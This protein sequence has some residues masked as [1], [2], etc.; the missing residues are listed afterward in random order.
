[1]S[2]QEGICTLTAGARV[3]DSPERRRPTTDETAGRLLVWVGGVALGGT[4]E[5]GRRARRPTGERLVDHRVGQSPS[6]QLLAQG[7]LAA[8]MR[9]IAGLDPG[10]GKRGVIQQP[11]ADQAVEGGLDELRPVAGVAE[12]ASRLVD[13]ARSRL[14]I[15]EPGSE[16]AIRIVDRRPVGAP[17]SLGATPGAGSAV[18]IDA[19]TAHALLGLL[20]ALHRDGNL[21]DPPADAI[22]DL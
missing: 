17:L 12:P 16:D 18:G 11:E 7:S 10:R 9:P 1:M 13:R 5:R 20:D 8:R 15:A 21:A 22:L 3:G 6:A 14:E 2:D 4:T 19:R